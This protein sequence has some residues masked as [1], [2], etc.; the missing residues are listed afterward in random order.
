[1]NGLSFS[2]GQLALFVALGIE[3]LAIVIVAAVLCFS[4]ILVV[5]IGRLVL[6]GLLHLLS[7]RERQ[8]TTRKAALLKRDSAGYIPL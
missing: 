6:P 2:L 5:G 3:H 8:A 1:M 7:Q 4:V